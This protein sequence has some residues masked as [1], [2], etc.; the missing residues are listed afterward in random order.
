VLS[1]DSDVASYRPLDTIQAAVTRRTLGGAPIGADEALTVEQ[2]VRAHTISAAYAMFAE[3]SLGSIEAGK[4]ADLAVID[5]DLFVAP[6]EEI[7]ALEV[8]MTVLDGEIVHTR[9]HPAP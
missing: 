6:A 9:A 7:A 8:W 3:D 2:A 1:S 4:L 5:G